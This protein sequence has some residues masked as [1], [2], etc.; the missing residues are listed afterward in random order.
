MAIS[1]SNQRAVS[2][3]LILQ[4]WLKKH[5]AQLLNVLPVPQNMESKTMNEESYKVLH[6]LL[7][8]KGIVSALN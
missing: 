3:P 5:K 7:S 8:E 2:T 1:P 6:R 4:E